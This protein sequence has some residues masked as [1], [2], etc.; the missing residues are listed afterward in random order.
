MARDEKL[1]KVV[2]N[3]LPENR[4]MR[5]LCTKLGFQ[6]FSS[7]EDNM[8]RAELDCSFSL[9]DRLIH[10]MQTNKRVLGSPER[11]F[12]LRSN[13]SRDYLTM[14]P[15]KRNVGPTEKRTLFWL[16]PRTFGEHVV[17]DIVSGGRTP[18]C[19]VMLKSMPPPNP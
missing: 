4:E 3:M 12:S 18:M 7:L 1:G 8:I 13:Y 5:A 14:L 17:V 6:M 9:A 2:S 19:L 10:L 15:P 16:L 11:A